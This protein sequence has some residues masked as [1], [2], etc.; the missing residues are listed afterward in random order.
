MKKIFNFFKLENLSEVLAYCLIV[1]T[2]IA[3][4]LIV[5]IIVYSIV[6]FQGDVN[7]EYF[8]KAWLYQQ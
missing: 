3:S 8:S 5:Q 4:L 2:I 6:F 1:L 7:A